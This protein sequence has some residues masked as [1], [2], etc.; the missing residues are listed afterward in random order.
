MSTATLEVIA[1]GK[2]TY[3][4]VE[5]AQKQ[6]ATSW[7]MADAIQEDYLEESMTRVI[8]SNQEV[9]EVIDGITEALRHA[10]QDYKRSTVKDYRQTAEAWPQAERVEGASFK[11][12]KM[13]RSG[14]YPNRRANLER[15][16]DRSATGK[17]T[18]HAVE[19]WI[20][21]KKPRSQ[22]SFL[23]LVDVRVR[24]ALKAAAKPW[25]TVAQDDR[26]AIARL[27]RIVADEVQDGSFPR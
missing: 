21:E 2:K 4:S 15:I 3:R 11:A 19:V 6:E 5:V 22:K 17:V 23:E 10:G 18:A 14:K 8:D 27:L 1:G 26:E 7:E 20:S 9:G 13:L 24:A 16:R 12:H 25:H